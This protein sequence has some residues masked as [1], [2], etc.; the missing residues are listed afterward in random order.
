MANYNISENDF[1]RLINDKIRSYNAL[2]GQAEVT[3][4]DHWN[5]PTKREAE[6]YLQAANVCAEIMAMNQNEQGTY[7]KWSR[8]KQACESRVEEIVRALNPQA[9]FTA[10]S[11]EPNE[12]ESRIS[13][14]SQSSATA[15]CAPRANP[16]AGSAAQPQE[17]FVT[18][19]A[20]KE[21]PKETIRSWY[22]EMPRRS[23]EEIVGME[24]I[25]DRLE[26]K[27]N[28]KRYKRTQARLGLEPM[29]SFVFYGPPGTG[30]TSVI[31]A[32]VHELMEEENFKFLH[33]VGG[34]I[35]DSL[36]G[37][38]E[39][40][41]TAVFQEAID[42]APCI[43]FV[44][45]LD[46]VCVERTKPNVAPHQKSLTVAFMEAYNRLKNSGKQVVFIGATNHLEDIDSAMLD[47]IILVQEIP[48]PNAQARES[49]FKL[50]LKNFHL[51]DGLTLAQM[52]EETEGAS[53]RDLDHLTEALVA[54]FG[55][56]TLKENVQT[57]PDGTEDLDATDIAGEQAIDSGASVV[58]R[59]LFEEKCAEVV[60]KLHAK[61]GD[62]K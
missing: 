48:L 37:V 53:F 20:T 21:V 46:N 47:R 25:R 11:A 61:Q 15:A 56:Q 10:A 35:H 42:N 14:R 7:G 49:Y 13:A 40:K 60:S 23:F 16:A 6:L 27:M 31:E 57:N 9:R 19:N 5:K 28:I 17:E 24:E 38:A 51:E 59:E 26:K 1:S 54:E 36:V 52:A 22:K 44:D 41:V 34:D 4:R 8:L 18:K 43:I 2:V 30:K 12:P 50:K 3:R 33:L 29:E 39:K 62:A 55:E 45:E 58:T 32:F